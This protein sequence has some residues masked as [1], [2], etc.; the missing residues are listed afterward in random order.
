[1]SRRLAVVKIPPSTLIG[2]LTQKLAV[3]IEGVPHDAKV[4]GI[5]SSA[6]RWM[7]DPEMHM[8]CVTIESETLEELR[9]GDRLPE[10][11]PLFT[12]RGDGIRLTHTL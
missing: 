1:M 7:Y 12:I 4:V 11:Y 9:E 2:L 5:G 8:I 3:R 10:I 6:D